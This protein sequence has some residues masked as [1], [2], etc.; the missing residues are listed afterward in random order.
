MRHDTGVIASEP[1]QGNAANTN[2]LHAVTLMSWHCKEWLLFPMNR[3]RS[4]FD[5]LQAPVFSQPAEERSDGHAKF[6]SSI[7]HAPFMSFHRLA[8]LLGPL[9]DVHDAEGAQ[10]RE[11]AGC[12]RRRHALPYAR[13][14]PGR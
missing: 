8:D 2:N 13:C 7:G 10:L 12:F 6:P 11:T 5:I 14:M 3:R 4:A 9:L 1:N